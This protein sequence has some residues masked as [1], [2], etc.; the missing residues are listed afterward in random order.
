MRTAGYCIWCLQ[1]AT[2][3]D[4]EHIFPEALGCPPDLTLSG[5]TVCRKCNNGLAHLDQAV[6]E[7]F[8]FLTVMNGIPRK[9]GRAAEIASR[10]NVYG[11]TT[12]N[13]PIIFFNLESVPHVTPNGRTLAPFR[14][15]ERDIRPVMKRIANGKGE[16][17]FEVA[18]GQHKKFARGLYKIALSSIAYY[19]GPERALKARYDWVRHYVRHGGARRHVLLTAASSP[20][21]EFACF[22]PFANES[23]DEAVDIR[24]GPAEF[25]LDMTENEVQLVTLVSKAREIF[26]AEGFSIFPVLQGDMER[27]DGS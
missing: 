3:K 6:A 20:R 1:A 11:T 18:F 8:D 4:V 27:P 16:I 24:I 15:R 23:G 17:S 19:L 5:T 21:F 25:L 9:G 7:D 26:G 10:G 2:D 12:S 22:P 13:G 14:G